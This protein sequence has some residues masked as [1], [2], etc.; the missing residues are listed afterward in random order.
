[1]E[2]LA[3]QSAVGMTIRIRPSRLEDGERAVAIWRSSVDASHHF[4]RSEDRQ[5]ID[6]QVQDFLPKMPMWLAV[7][8]DDRPIG[9]MILTNDHMD[10][11]FVHATSRGMGVGRALVEFA[12]S[13]HP[14]LST[15]VNEQN[16]QAIGFYERMGFIRTGRSALDGQGR[17]YPLVYLRKDVSGI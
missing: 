14:R 13:M 1:M 8:E 16:L 6:L 15:D 4:L 12:L 17:P 9:F 3:R 11:L 2:A 5:A 10:G 7:A